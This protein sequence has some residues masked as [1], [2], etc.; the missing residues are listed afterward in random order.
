MAALGYFWIAPTPDSML[1]GKE[2]HL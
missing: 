1:L 2:C